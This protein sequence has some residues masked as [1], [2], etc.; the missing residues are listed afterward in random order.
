MGLMD[1]LM[2]PVCTLVKRKCPTCKVINTLET[3]WLARM[4]A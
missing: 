3:S 4:E 1:E 2:D